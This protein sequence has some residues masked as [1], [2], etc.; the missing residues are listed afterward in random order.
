MAARFDGISRPVLSV[1]V[2]NVFG[3]FS[4]D[5]D[6]LARSAARCQWPSADVQVPCI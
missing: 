2:G 4:M 3:P 6:A 1:N 5:A